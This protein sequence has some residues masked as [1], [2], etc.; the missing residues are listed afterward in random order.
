MSA[1]SAPSRRGDRWLRVAGA[2]GSGALLALA[3]PRMDRGYVAWIALLPLLA[4]VRGSRPRAAAALGWICGFVFYAAT[5]YWVPDTIGNF[6]TISTTVATGLWLLMAAAA[7][8]SHALFAAALEW[9]ARSGRS[10][11]LAAPLLWV[12]IEW[13]RTFV[14]AEFPWNFLG[15]ALVPF[16]TLT[17]LADVTGVYGLSAALVLGN[18]ALA[19]ALWELRRFGA[20]AAG[21]MA[22]ARPGRARRLL[23]IA[24]LC[25]ILLYGYGKA[26]LAQLATQPYTGSL[27][28]AVVQ[29]N[30]AQDQK[31]VP[32]LQ[33]EIFSVYLALSEEA[34]DAGA[35]LVVWPEA[36]LP[37]PLEFD[38]RSH[39]LVELARR[40][41]VDLLIGTP[42]FR[43]R[44]DGGATPYNE[45]WLVRADGTLG[46]PYAKIQLVPFGEYIPL[47]GL[48]GMVD[49]AVEAVGQLGR[50]DAFTIF[51]TGPAATVLAEPDRAPVPVRFATLICYEGIFPGLTRRFAAAGVD[52]L[53]NI[54]ND[55]WY[56]DTAAPDQHL[57]MASLRAI[58]NRVPLV[59]S[60]NTGVSAFVTA[61]GWIGARTPLFRREVAT[62][63]VLL[64]DVWSFYRSFGDV[65]LFSSIAAVAAMCAAAIANRRRRRAGPAGR[66]VDPRPLP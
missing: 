17:Q 4:A 26:R 32:E 42:G 25:P 49:I 48:F 65:F 37:F 33:D 43:A 56:G 46:G 64:R 60:T 14:I 45:A 21:A 58:E 19:E 15:Y 40:R 13:M 50:G 36:A 7:A 31:W 23:A 24:L 3:F 47:Y 54:S 61:Q 57:A 12:A 30:V 27:T 5:L 66:D 8:Y 38:S 53:V 63:T 11:L 29:G 44:A 59:R 22:V 55:A 16:V 52:F 51:E 6:T 62:E 41:G 2:I 10:R 28:V 1:G 20:G 34:A 9:L 35:R 18:V 39:A